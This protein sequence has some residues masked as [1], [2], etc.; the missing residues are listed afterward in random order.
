MRRIEK[1][2]SSMAEK[3]AKLMKEINAKRKQ[4]KNKDEDDSEWEDVDEHEKEV[5]QT[6]GYFDVP[7]VD[8]Q[9]S[10]A[11]QTLLSKMNVK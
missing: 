3:K 11:D 1:G 9:I 6:T 5:Y 8:A 7:D 10:K 4:K 2:C